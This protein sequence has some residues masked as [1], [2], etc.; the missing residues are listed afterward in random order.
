MASLFETKSCTRCGGSGRYSFN[1]MNGDRCFGCGGSGQQLTK[2]GQAAQ[3]FYRSL[4]EKPLSEVKAGDN[5]LTATGGI[6]TGPDRWHFVV[7]VGPCATAFNGVADRLE[8]TFKRRGVVSSIGGW[9]PST[10]VRSVRN[11]D[12]RLAFVERALAYQSTLTKAG[13]PSA[14]AAKEIA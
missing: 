2:R 3:A 6:G 14:R 12:E 5:I 11:E 4:L 8:V 10:V 9:T 7:S 13:K 1:L